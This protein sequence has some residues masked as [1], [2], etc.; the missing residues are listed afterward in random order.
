M[1]FVAL[2]F[3]SGSEDKASACSAGDQSSI[4]GSGRSPGEERG[5]PLQYSSLKNSMDRGAWWA[6]VHR[7]K[8][9]Q[10]RLK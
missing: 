5:N 10:T 8:K 2:G 3:L 9:N 1:I 4:P 7:D 6:K